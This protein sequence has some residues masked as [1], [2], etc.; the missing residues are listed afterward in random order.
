VSDEQ[1]KHNRDTDVNASLQMRK[2]AEI[3]FMQKPSEPQKGDSGQDLARQ[4][5]AGERFQ[6]PLGPLF[7]YQ[8]KDEHAEHECGEAKGSDLS[9]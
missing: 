4:F 2:A 9:I 3:Q 6:G 7:A 1:V 8:D 5:I